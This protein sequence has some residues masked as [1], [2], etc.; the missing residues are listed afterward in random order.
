MMNSRSRIAFALALSL[1]LFGCG[2]DEPVFQPPEVTVATPERR[3]V[4]EFFDFTGTTRALQYAEIR[5]RVSGVLEE[6]H[7][8][9]GGIVEANAPL[10]AWASFRIFKARL[11]WSSRLLVSTGFLR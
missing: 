10:R 7:F 3:A 5:A 1:V 9:P 6:I 2:D 8:E 4:Q 11:T